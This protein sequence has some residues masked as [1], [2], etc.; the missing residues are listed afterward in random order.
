MCNYALLVINLLIFP[1]KA[2]DKSSD[3][4]GGTG[5]QLFTQSKK[6]LPLFA[7]NSDKQLRIILNSFGL[8]TA[9]AFYGIDLCLIHDV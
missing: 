2:A 5:I 4:T 8:F 9:T 1:D 7:I 3:F 6:L